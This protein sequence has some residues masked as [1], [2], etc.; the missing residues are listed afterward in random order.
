METPNTYLVSVA[1]ALVLSED[2]KQHI[3]TSISTLR[4]RLNAWFG[5]DVKKQ[6]QFGSILPRSV[7]SGSDINHVT[8]DHLPIP[9]DMESLPIFHRAE[10]HPRF[11]SDSH[12]R[13]LQS[14]FFRRMVKLFD[15]DFDELRRLDFQRFWIIFFA[16]DIA[17]NLCRRRGYPGII[18]HL[19]CH[20]AAIYGR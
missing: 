7:D 19:V 5:N 10:I 6:Y 4:A 20:L 3:Q 14:N 11:S 1:R 13:G 2:E 15:F 9:V 17:G 12:F 8:V 18:R 16:P